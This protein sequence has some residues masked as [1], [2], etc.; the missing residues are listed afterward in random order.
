M[1]LVK[2]TQEKIKLA[3]KEATINKN[4]IK[5]LL[6]FDKKIIVHIN[7]KNKNYFAIRSQHN[8]LRGPYKGGIRFSPGINR[9]EVCA[10][11]IWMSLK[12]SLVDIPFG[13]GKGG[14]KIDPRKI[15]E[16]DQKKILKKFITKISN[17]IG[18]NKD[19]LAPDVNTD[20]NIM[21]WLVEAYHNAQPKEKNYL[22]VTTGKPVNQGGIEGRAEATSWG[23][24]FV[25]R[26]FLDYS[27]QSIKNISVAIHGF[28]NAAIYY[29]LEI[30][31]AGGK[32]VAVSDS[33]GGIYNHRFSQKLSQSSDYK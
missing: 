8:N 4:L 22:A 28:G 6:C 19:I 33:S 30:E 10:L 27:K 29:G 21:K 31:K 9:D 2:D 11:S 17:Q 32:V 25:L 7:H 5:K 23:A 12:T 26:S 13:G 15:S 20:E 24:Y 18:P 14:I 1:N 16:Q 3:G